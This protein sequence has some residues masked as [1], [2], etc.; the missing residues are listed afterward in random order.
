MGKII[1]FSAILMLLFGLVACGGGSKDPYSG[2][3]TPDGDQKPTDQDKATP[4][5][6]KDSDDP[7][8]NDG[9]EQEPDGETDP[10]PDAEPD[11][12]PDGG[13]DDEPDGDSETPETDG[14]TAQPDGDVSPHQAVCGDGVVDFGEVCDGGTTTCEELDLGQGTAAFGC[15]SDCSGWE[16]AGLC[17]KE[18][19]AC[20]G[21]PENAHWSGPETV[22]QTWDGA[23]WQPP[24]TAAHDESGSGYPC[25][26]ECDL[27]YEWDFGGWRCK[28]SVTLLCTG[29]LDCYNETERMPMCPADSQNFF[30]QDANYI[31]E[32]LCILP[33][34]SQ[35]NPYVDILTDSNT[36]LQ[37]YEY[38][39]IDS[40]TYTDIRNSCNNLVYGGFDDWRMP[41]IYELHTIFNYG[42]HDPAVTTSVFKHVTSNRLW[43]GTPHPTIEKTLWIVSTDFGYTIYQKRAPDSGDPEGVG[44][45]GILC[46][47]G[48]EYKFTADSIEL[49]ND[50]T[51][52]D[53][54]NS[55]MWHSAASEE[56]KTWAEALS[57][58]EDST[59]GGHTNWRLPNVTELYSLVDYNAAPDSFLAGL[60]G[61]S[62]SPK[63]KFWTSTTFDAD[64]QNAWYIGFDDGLVKDI[65]KSAALRVRCV[66]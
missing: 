13:A 36:G 61:D 48:S 57:Y 11:E 46:V 31:V 29:Q 45:V 51:F 14:D 33:G 17:V 35:E 12:E 34:V 62:T 41:T 38:M 52:Y 53:T 40:N 1:E 8:L 10:D 63:E 55:R 56:P 19:V 22:K 47:R 3:D 18:D 25:S 9:D 65:V 6:D 44:V 59:L 54:R 39:P 49:L 2:Y 21:L 37:W 27:T 7:G 42:K 50:G 26:F 5:S 32:S 60:G 66:R 23:A 20:L 16:N 58:C 4:D 24:N 64:P 43:S 15:K 30:G 28:P